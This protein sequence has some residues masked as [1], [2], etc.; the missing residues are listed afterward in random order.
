MLIRE[1]DKEVYIA[2]LELFLHK[3][4][5][6]MEEKYDAE[7]KY[8]EVDEDDGGHSYYRMTRDQVMSGV[9]DDFV[10]SGEDIDP[11]CYD[12]FEWCIDEIYRYGCAKENP[13]RK[14]ENKIREQQ[15]N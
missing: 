13:Y 5:K 8:D 14:L 3:L 6:R 2:I 1:Q 15:N 9:T 10:Q 11:D 7:E 12:F 4:E